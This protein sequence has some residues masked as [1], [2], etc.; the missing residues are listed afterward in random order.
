MSYDITNGVKFGS[1]HSYKDFGLILKKR[2]ELPM[3]EAKTQYVDIPGMD[4]SIDMTNAFGTVKYNNRNIKFTF[5]VIGDRDNWYTRHSELANF[6]HGQQMK[7][8]I[9]EDKKY[10]YLGRPKVNDWESNGNQATLVVDALCEPFK[11]DINQPSDGGWLWDPFS[12]VDGVIFRDKLPVDGTQ[13]LKITINYLPQIPTFTCDAPGM[14]VT[15][16]GE[17]YNLSEGLNKI[18]EI[19]LERGDNFLTFAGTGNVKIGYKVASL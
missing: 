6:L 9:D 18:F 17:T 16:K 13:N 8:I 12:F 2:P 7:I 3:P 1:K 15:F 10:Y 11:Y 19:E 5:K 14:S 4:G